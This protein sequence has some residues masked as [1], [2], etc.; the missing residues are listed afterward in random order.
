MRRLKTEIPG[1]DQILSGGIPELATVLIA[2]APGTGKTI[3]AQNILFNI[4]RHNEKVMYVSTIAEPQIKVLRY[5]QEF[6][7]FSQSA[8]MDSVIY[9]DLG[10]IIQ[11]QGIM[12]SL[13]KLEEN[14]NEHNP[15]LI[16][17]D[18]IKAVSDYIGSGQDFRKYIFDL[19]VRF[20]LWG[21]TV[22]FLGE[23]N[24]NQVQNTAEAAMVDD[25][26][27]LYGTEERRYQKRYLRVL[28]MRGTDFAPGE[29]IM[30]ISND[31]ISVYPRV[32]AELNQNNITHGSIQLQS[33]GILG[34]DE[35]TNGGLP[36]GTTTLI[37][38]ATGTGK[39][40]LGLSWLRQG[41]LEGEPGLLISFD[42][43]KEQILRT[44]NAF[45]WDL[46]NAIQ[47]GMLTIEHLSPVELDVDLHLFR[48]HSLAEQLGAKRILLDS[49]STFEIGMAD[50]VKY[51]DYIWGLANYFKSRGI[52]VTLVAESN[53]L[54]DIQVSKHGISYIAD[55]IIYLI[56]HR[57]DFTLTRLIGV[58]KMRGCAHCGEERQYIIGAQGP[59]VQSL[60]PA[61]GGK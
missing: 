19:N 55:N 12:E 27:Y 24:E 53:A 58:L 50:K 14:A 35:M 38:G 51:T 41:I 46:S 59:Q 22:I 7:F 32:G 9:C 29:H 31:G 60:P 16:V 5:Q 33:T 28:K 42:E 61:L 18:S 4:A 39:S 15:A 36:A 10:S 40:I 20:S 34:L 30:T 26:I 25:I 3:L 2:G 23:Y 57:Q 6:S 13:N 52:S 54:Y 44:G 37:T 8:F 49:I 17:I 45:A 56:F 47:D 48:V 1:L 11:S 43:S 21:C